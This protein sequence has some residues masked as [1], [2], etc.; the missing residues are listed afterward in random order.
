MLRAKNDGIYPSHDVLVTANALY[1]TTAWGGGS[2]NCTGQIPG[3]GLALSL[4]GP[5]F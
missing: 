5:I 3:C 2:A 1:T 4:S